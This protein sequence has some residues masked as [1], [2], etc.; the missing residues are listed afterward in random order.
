[1][2]I[3]D[4]FKEK[5][6]QEK[7]KVSLENL[8]SWIKGQKK[9]IKVNEDNF[10]KLIERRVL[11]VI[12]ELE[13]NIK[14]LKRVSLDQKK[15]EDRVKLIVKENLNYYII[16][17]EKLIKS[18]KELEKPETEKINKIFFDFEKRSSLNFEKATFLIGKELEAVKKT[19]D[20]FFKEL[21]GELN[22]NK[23]LLEKIKN[24]SLIDLK[25]NEINREELLKKQ[26]EQN[27]DNLDKKII[28]YEKQIKTIQ[29]DISD[30]RKSKEYLE[31]KKEEQGF[32]EK[33]QELK[34]LVFKLKESIDF[35]SLASTFHS[36]YKKMSIIKEHMDSFLDTLEKDSGR[37]ITTLL[38]EAGLNKISFEGEI[39]KILELKKQTKAEINR[40]QEIKIKDFENEITRINSDIIF[41]KEEHTREIKKQERV[42]ENKKNLINS[43]KNELTKMNTEII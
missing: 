18:L 12:D 11:Q 32:E 4:L 33:K 2:G 15:V 38:N 13:N 5:K 23:D 26:L 30:L 42:E 3:F 1:M 40:K 34:R 20:N 41:L 21:K 28:I 6:Q 8:E 19:I 36:D 14:I 31:E 39:S 24:I 16:N 43:L 17:L 35:K 9:E 10:S 25:I 22:E 7:Q 29:K 27:L 37:N